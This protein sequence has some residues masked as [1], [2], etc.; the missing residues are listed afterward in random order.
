MR[1]I[2]GGMARVALAVVDGPRLA[3]GSQANRKYR[4]S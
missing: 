3:T 1:G 2:Q 4:I